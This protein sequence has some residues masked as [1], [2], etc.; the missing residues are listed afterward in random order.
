MRIEEPGQLYCNQQRPMEARASPA[1]ITISLAASGFLPESAVEHTDELVGRGASGLVRKGTMQPKGGGARLP[2]AIKELAPGSTEREEVAFM[3]E[4]EL[5][6]AASQHCPGACRL[7]GCVHRGDALC[8]VMKYYPSSL[9]AQLEARRDPADDSRRLPMPCPLR[10]CC[11]S[12]CRSRLR[13][14]SSTRSRSWFAT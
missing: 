10:R 7:Y 11:P 1:G 5:G 3:R 12:A 4:F 14:P 6:F 13:W 2:V 8:L 9:M